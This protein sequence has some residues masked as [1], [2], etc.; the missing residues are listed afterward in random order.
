MVTMGLS[1]CTQ[2]GQS[3]RI[4]SGY[5]TGAGLGGTGLVAIGLG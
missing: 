1:D 2:Y 4:G 5:Q 3:N